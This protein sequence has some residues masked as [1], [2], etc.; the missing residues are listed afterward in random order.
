MQTNF[1]NPRI[2][3]FANSLDIYSDADLDIFLYENLKTKKNV[4]KI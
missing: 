3:L 2:L 4:Y 1:K